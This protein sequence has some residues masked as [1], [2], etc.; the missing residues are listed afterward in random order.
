MSVNTVL[1]YKPK[2]EALGFKVSDTMRE[3]IIDVVDFLESLSFFFKLTMF[4]VIENNAAEVEYTNGAGRFTRFEMMLN[5]TVYQDNGIPVCWSKSMWES[6][7]F[8]FDNSDEMFES[9][10]EIH[11]LNVNEY[12]P[13]EALR[14][15]LEWCRGNGLGLENFGM[16]GNG[17]YYIIADGYE[18]EEFGRNDYV[19]Q[20]EHGNFEV[21]TK[22]ELESEGYTVQDDLPF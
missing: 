4:R 9:A 8:Y 11:A 12:D 14:G 15:I 17:I 5:H 19:F 3:Q 7:G 20:N 22:E 6:K 2:G 13:V 1:I 21:W 10:D 16:S 18:S